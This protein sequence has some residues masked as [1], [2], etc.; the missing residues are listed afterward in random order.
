MATNKR[1]ERLLARHREVRQEFTKLRDSR[2]YKYAHI[3][4]KLSEKYHYSERRVE[5]IIAIDD[6]HPLYG[7]V[8]QMKLFE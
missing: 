6:T 3:L 1:K 2:K 7:N 4:T 5:E 8:N